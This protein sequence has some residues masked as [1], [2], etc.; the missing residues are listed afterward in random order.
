MPILRN[1]FITDTL[2]NFSR[3]VIPALLYDWKSLLRPWSGGD[4]N[5]NTS[6]RSNNKHGGRQQLTILLRSESPGGQ[7]SCYALPKIIRGVES[8]QE[9]FFCTI[10]VTPRSHQKVWWRCTKG[11]EW[12]AVVSSRTRGSACPYCSSRKKAV[13]T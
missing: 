11:H 12:E 1:S 6:G 7:Q 2:L 4:A 9:P 13:R 5:R 10:D 8:S 3:F